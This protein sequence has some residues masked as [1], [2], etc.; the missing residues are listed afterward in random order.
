MADTSFAAGSAQAVKYYSKMTFAETLKKTYIGKFMGKAGDLDSIIVRLQ[1]FEKRAGERVYYD[2]LML[3]VG[4]GVGGDNTLEYNEEAMVYHQDDLIIDQRR[5]AHSWKRMSQQRTLHQLRNDARKNMGKWMAGTIYDQYMFNNLCGLTSHNHGQA[6]VVPDTDHYIV[7]GDVTHDASIVTAETSLSTNDQIGL[8]DLDYAKEKAATITPP[9]IPVTYDGQEY[10]VV[11]LHPFSGT[12]I[13]L[14][15]V[16]S[17]YTNW[18]DIQQYASKRGMK[19]PIFTNSL[20]VYNGM[21]LMESNRICLFDGTAAD[22][23]RRNLFLGQQAGVFAVGSAYDRI[24]EQKYGKLPMSWE[25]DAKDY[26]NRKGIAVGSIFGT[27]ACIF[28]GKRFGS[29]IITA[30]SVQH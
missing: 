27:K 14:N 25:E 12:D 30:Y 10:F 24:D 28:N 5:N 1:D 17:T 2:L 9:M 11:V 16:T 20:G 19:N 4:T 26:R 23:V 15:T 18:Q 7:T 21:I 22:T 6:A 29:M 3:P 13:R 8:V